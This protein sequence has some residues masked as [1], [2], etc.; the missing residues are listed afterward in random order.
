[1][2]RPGV[3]ALAIMAV[4]TG[5]WLI[6]SAS[7]RKPVNQPTSGAARALPTTFGPSA[8]PPGLL[9]AQVDVGSLSRSE[10]EAEVKRRDA[11]DSKWEW[12]MPIQFYGKVIDDNSEPV[13]GA[14]VHFQWTDLS[15]NGTSDADTITD[16]QGLF[17]LNDA[18]GKRLLVH[19]SK[20]GY[21][22]SAARNRRS[23][24]FANPFEEIY[25]Q[26]KATTPVLF[27]LREQRPVAELIR[28]SAEV[29]LPGDG[30]A[31][32]I[33]LET[34]LTASDGQLEVKAWKPWPPR[35]MSPPYD[36]KVKLT[37]ADGGFVESAEEF[38]FNAPDARYTPSFEIDM[39][40][41]ATDKWKV[42]GERTLYFSYGA[43]VKYGHLS[44]RTDG[45]SRYIFIDY[46]LNP[47]GSRNLEDGPPRPSSLR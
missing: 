30:S 17:H 19:V 26:P 24:E 43:P 25:Y 10:V 16:Q 34:G 11:Q 22:P 6:T 1:M 12:K 41:S 42:S 2:R 3:V 28:R 18:Q 36:W 40:A 29:V 46:V 4:V 14:R 23:F 21:Y 8:S 45:N 9:N 5:A 15:G 37:I 13:P 7:R 38:P 35:P 44:L 20:P 39:L 47:S 31:A 33:C 27:H 32:K